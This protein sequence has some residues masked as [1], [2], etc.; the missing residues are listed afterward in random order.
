MHLLHALP[1][2]LASAGAASVFKCPKSDIRAT[3]CIGPKDCLYA[4]SHNCDT[5]IQ[6]IVN[7]DET[8]GTPVVMPCPSGL[9]WND[10]EKECDWPA[11]AACGG[12]IEI[13]E[14]EAQEAIPPSDGS[15]NPSFSCSDAQASQGSKP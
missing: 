4:N 2:V 3:K 8:T 12:E 15:I 6:C 10:K 14:D 1:L 11:N 9:Q 5:F 7:A 13:L